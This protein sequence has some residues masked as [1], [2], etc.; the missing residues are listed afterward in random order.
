MAELRNRLE[1]DDGAA[2]EVLI[3]D[4]SVAYTT[5]PDKEVLQGVSLSVERGSF[6]GITGLNGAG[7]STLCRLIAGYIPHFFDVDMTGSVAVRGS[8]TAESGIGELAETVGFVFENPFDQLSGANLTVLEEAAFA[9]EN[10]G[11]PRQDIERRARASLAAVG[12]EDLAD[13]DPA[14]LSGGQT[15]RLALASVLA[16]RP[17]IIVLDDPTSQLDPLGAED[18][19]DVLDDLHQQGF[20]V[21]VVSQD[22]EQL[23]PRVDRLVVLEAGRV[24]WNDRPQIVLKNAVDQSYP[25]A[26]PDVV[27]V[28]HEL[29]QR[30]LLPGAPEPPLTATE[31]VAAIA[32][33]SPA[34]KAGSAFLDS[35]PATNDTAGGWARPDSSEVEQLSTADGTKGV[36]FNDVQ[37]VYPGD[38]TALQNLSLNL[39]GGC[40]C[41]IG[42]NGAGKSTF[43]RH[44]NGLLKPTAGTVKVVGQDTAGMNVSVLARDVGL[45][46]QNPDDQLFRRT[47]QDEVQFGPENIGAPDAEVATRANEA[48]ELL[49]LLDVKEQK[50]HDLDLAHRKHVA[51]ASVLAMDTPVLVLDEP[52][53]GQDAQ[54]TELL[55]NLVRQAASRGKTVIVITHDMHFAARYADRVVVLAEGTL[56]ADGD[57]RS[58]FGQPEVLRRGHVTAPATTRLA[59]GL[60]LTS[61][62]L[63]P[64]ELVAELAG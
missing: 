8:D 30:D 7:K 15:Q 56:L 19:F 1:A 10:M 38:V 27:H 32:A 24:L 44:L 14:K 20:T 51:T 12:I 52:T 39:E 33:R 35:E 59:A 22:L 57:A 21:V 29:R 46:F 28:W 2:P 4:V 5:N 40:I 13:R 62:P 6:I 18:V 58:V 49:G 55:G 31:A 16:L 54:G 9:L 23:A 53:G 43:A 25:L 11:V 48:M 64:A 61:L 37:Y 60:G 17:R 47:V 45:A 63:S 42:Q 3:N 50:P 34:T 26:V 41:V 36:S